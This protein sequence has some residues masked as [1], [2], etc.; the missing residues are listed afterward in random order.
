MVL[1]NSSLPLNPVLSIPGFNLNAS[2]GAIFVGLLVSGMW[3]HHVYNKLLLDWLKNKTLWDYV[4]SDCILLWKAFPCGLARSQIC[5][6]LM[7]FYAS[8]EVLNLTPSFLG[9]DII[10]RRLGVAPM[11]AFVLLTKYTS[12]I[13]ASH[14]AFLS[15]TVFTYLVT[16]FGDE[17]GI[18]RLLW[19]TSV[20]LCPLHMFSGARRTL[21]WY[22]A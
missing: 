1:S 13:D 8:L 11:V 7:N 10:V 5:C 6:T 4:G 12:V 16:D 21:I 2:L 17:I 18:L 15:H 9:I 14:I 22:I 3:V 19:S 20:S